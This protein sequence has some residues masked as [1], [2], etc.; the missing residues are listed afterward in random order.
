[1]WMN[2]H[3]RA[4]TNAPPV[5]HISTMPTPRPPDSPEPAAGAARWLSGLAIPAAALGVLL[6]AR[7]RP[8]DWL[9]W[10]IPVLL[11]IVIP[12]LD[13]LIGGHRANPSER[14]AA[15]AR[16][17]PLHRLIP[18]LFLPLQW[19]VIGTAV[20]LAARPATSWVAF[21]GL[22]LTVGA[23]NG[24][25]IVVAHEIGHQS[26]RLAA[27]A[28]RLAL[29]PSFYGHF[30]IEHNRGHHLRVATPDDP[31]SARLG[32][33]FWR[34]LPRTVLGGAASAWRIEAERLAR[35]G[36]PAWSVFNECLQSHALTLALLAA[37]SCFGN[38]R[39]A[40]FA[41]LQAAYSVSLLEA[42]NYIEHYG[43]RRRTI[44]GKVEPC[45]PRH[46]WNCD[47]RLSNLLLFNLQRHSDHHAH[48][49][50]R[51]EALRTDPAYPRLPT[52][53]AG[54]MWAVY[55]P[56]L[57]STL[58]D[59]RVMQACGGDLESANVDPRN[60][61]ALRRQWPGVQRP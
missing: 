26:G 52:G 11:F 55:L 57:W 32:E 7:A 28:A 60:A 45:S 46:S 30:R 47:A 34:F 4:W 56:P 25:A 15:Q 17:D 2:W 40:L 18:F 50:R 24:I 35:R 27:V 20:A 33:S 22:V 36:R 39:V 1:M 10:C 9:F 12:G 59:A 6:A 8:V 42:I 48:A 61:A 53:Y 19:A 41:L 49:T 43:L 29:A 38:G 58:M 16:R 54:L 31:A 5:M 23:V 3:R 21:A 14:Q 37:A 13:A 51:Y 44:A